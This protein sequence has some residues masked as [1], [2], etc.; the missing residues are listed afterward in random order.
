MQPRTLLG[1]SFAAIALGAATL[2][3]ARRSEPM[4]PTPPAT[5][6]EART[7][8]KIESVAEALDFLERC[9]P[10]NADPTLAKEACRILAKANDPAAMNAL[11]RH[12]DL[13]IASGPTTSEETLKLMTRRKDFSKTMR[14]EYPAFAALRGIGKP[15]TDAAA[16]M[17]VDGAPAPTRLRSYLLE[18]LLLNVHGR[19]EAMALI[20][21]KKPGATATSGSSNP[22][23]ESTLE[24]LKYMAIDSY[25]AN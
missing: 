8:E 15:T 12:I 17:L 3:I 5:V 25:Q 21:Q 13:H 1:I 24:D 11:L 14:D 20:I 10:V 9:D 19:D 2:W 4:P 7:V 22:R 18:Q 16:A 6:R 23:V